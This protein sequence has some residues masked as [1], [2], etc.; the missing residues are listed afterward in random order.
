MRRPQHAMVAMLVGFVVSKT[1]M[2]LSLDASRDSPTVLSNLALPKD[3]NGGPLI[4]GEADVLVYNGSFYF[5]F[6]NWGNC[7]GV[8]CC[9][10]EVGCR[11]CCYFVGEPGYP[12]ATCVETNNHSVVVYRTPDFA[13]WQFLGEALPASARPDPQ[14][15]YR[16]HVVWNAK[17]ELFVMWYN[18]FSMRD[19]V[20][21][22]YGCLLYTS[23]SPRDATL[24]RMPSSA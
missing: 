23:P 6:N 13:T 4:T 7:S 17:T 20:R 21:F 19:E 12:A 2:A 16:P 8:D 15:E 22:K 9:G 14:I 3:A 11:D 10:T 1:A 5:Y 24:S 18:R